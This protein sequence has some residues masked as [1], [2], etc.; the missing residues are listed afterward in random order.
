ML[1][2]KTLPAFRGVVGNITTGQVKD[3]ELEPDGARRAGGEFD[4]ADAL[5]SVAEERARVREVRGESGCHAPVVV[6]VFSYDGSI[7]ALVQEEAPCAEGVLGAGV[8]E[9]HSRG[10]LQR[11]R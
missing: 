7:L 10:L 9:H 1:R 4:G 2:L 3:F 5:L 11:R 6:Q 8:V